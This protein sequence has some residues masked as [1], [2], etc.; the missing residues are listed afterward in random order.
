MKRPPIPITVTKYQ[1]QHASTAEMES[2]PEL[3]QM[4]IRTYRQH[5]VWGGM[6]S[7]KVV[8]DGMIPRSLN[9][10]Y[11]RRGKN[12]YDLHSTVKVFRDSFG[13]A[14]KTADRP[15]HL[16]GATAAVCLFYSPEW[17]TKASTIRNADVDNLVKSTLDA[18]E[19]ATGVED[20]RNWAVHAFKVLSNIQRTVLYLF[21]IS[22]GVV[23]YHAFPESK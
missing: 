17:V 22:Q 4:L 12:I 21:E 3:A 16:R 7:T 6:F 23:A 10:Q 2:V 5:S 14:A 13:W 1:H 9:H 19:L 20:C 15:V 18:Y 11:V 8:L